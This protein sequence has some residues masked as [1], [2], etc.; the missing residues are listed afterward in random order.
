MHKQNRS[1]KISGARKLLLVAAAVCMM[2]LPVAAGSAL[3]QTV[4]QGY[5]SD[6]LLQKGMMVAV[7]ADDSSKVEALKPESLDRLVGV[8]VDPNDSPV[9]LS[10]DGQKVFVANSGTF[11]VLV[12]DQNGPIKNGDYI[13][14]SSL[15]GIGMKADDSQEIV[16]GRAASGFEG[17]GD[18]IGSTS[19]GDF[20]KINFGRIHVNIAINKNP[21]KKTPEKDRIPDFL[22]RVGG[23]IADKP[24]NAS[25]IYAAAAIFTV[26]AIITGSMLYSGIRNSLVAIGRNPLSKKTITRSLMQVVLFSLIVFISGLFGVYLL[27]KL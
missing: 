18:S 2:S 15:A 5:G 1:K 19:T 20:K 3:A 12:S 14:V 4:T 8:I 6:E 13:S 17:K 24:V 23:A 22:Q 9:T 26:S 16:V 10:R 11:E 27:L 25:R 7:R 21:L